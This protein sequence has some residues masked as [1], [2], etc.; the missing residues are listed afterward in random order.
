MTTS[1]SSFSE[2]VAHSA[3]FGI[4]G[5]LNALLNN[6]EAIMKH[7]IRDFI[8]DLIGIIAIVVLFYATAI[9]GH[10]LGL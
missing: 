7:R 8:G 9:I 10:G 6:K 1:Q 4:S 2:Y 3:S 5:E